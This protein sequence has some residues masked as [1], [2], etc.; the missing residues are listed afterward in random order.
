MCPTPTPNNLMAMEPGIYNPAMAAQEERTQIWASLISLWDLPETSIMIRG[1][2]LCVFFSRD[3]QT[4]LFC[5][6]F[7]F[8]DFGNHWLLKS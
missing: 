8:D 4:H 2:I 7:F 3:L 1:F 6:I 5:K